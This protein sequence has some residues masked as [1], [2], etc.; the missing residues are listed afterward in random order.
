MADKHPGPVVDTSASRHARLRPV[1]A[2]DVRITDDFWAP[3]LRRNREVTIPAQ[4]AQCEST[5]ALRNFARAAGSAD[6]D[7]SGRYY[8]DSDV[9]KWIEAASWSMATHPSEELA[10]RLDSVIELVAGAQ[11]PDGY[12]NTYFSVD[13]VHERWTDLVVRH[14]MYCVGHLVAAAVAHARATGRSTLLDVALRACAHIADRFTPGRV[15]G[16]CGHPGL[17]MALVELYRTTGDERWLT[18]ATWQLD[19]RGR[20]VLD[21]SEYLVD[22]QPVR[23]QDRVTGHA[24]RALYLYSGMADVVL[25]TGDPELRAALERLWAD[26]SGAKTAVTGGV[27]ARWDGEAF[28]DAYELPDRSYNETCAAIAHIFLAWRLLLLTGEP[29]YRD[30]V[31]TA[32]HNGVLPGLSLSGTEFFYQ[33]PLA[34]AGRHRRA[35]WFSCACCPPNIAR[36]LASLPGYLYTTDDDGIQVQL[37]IG[38]QAELRLADGIPVRLDLAT[39]LPWR[40]EVRLTVDPAEP[41]EFT[42]TLP[43]PGW[44]G[45]DVTVRVN[46]DPVAL[47]T[48]R[49]RI[50]LRRT[51][52]AGDTVEVT[53]PTEVRTLVGH[54]RVT[55]V[56]RRAAL[57]MGPLVYC[58]EQADHHGTAVADIRLTGVERWTVAHEPELLG[59]VC[60]LSAQA[61][62]APVDDGPLYRPYREPAA[63]TSGVSVTAVP[64][65]AWANR[66]P[67]EMRV[68][69]PLA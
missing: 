46:G 3:R 69:V 15:T 33:N 18:L 57:A 44:A 54:P 10:D 17:E 21:G 19:S 36:L 16:A 22:H 8:S 65:F 37:Y 30:V 64:Y 56:H 58:L 66:T 7:F 5:G 50:A 41:R 55:A 63:P 4:H 47:D 43:V 61:G 20:G 2:P 53:L 24:V 14:E 1:S 68:F 39:E 45:A 60:T 49:R 11:D 67:G 26:L 40:G 28:G 38:N 27:G 29:Q 32:L 6:G 31:E 34:D 13:R 59:G 25:E 35:E 12:L 48:G 23:Q 42:V 52:S 62:A 9:Y 51:W